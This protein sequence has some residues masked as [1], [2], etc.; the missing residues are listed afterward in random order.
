MPLLEE[1]AQLIRDVSRRTGRKLRVTTTMTI[2]A[3]DLAGVPAV[4]RWLAA[5]TDVFRH[6]SFQPVAQV[7]RTAELLSA[8][9]D[10]S[11]RERHG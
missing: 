4:V 5:H 9:H 11:S 10:D 3:D 8:S 1:F 7:G 6:V 2:T